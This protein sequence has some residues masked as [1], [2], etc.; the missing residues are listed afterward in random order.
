MFPVRY[1]TSGLAV[2]TTSRALSA[3]GVSIRSLKAPPDGA[4]VSM[5]MYLP[6]SRLPEVAIG[7]VAHSDDSGGFW[8]DFVLL[9]P[10]ARARIQ[11]LVDPAG[12]REGPSARRAFAR[13]SVDLRVR[14]R[15]AREFAIESASNLSRA[16]VFIRCEEPPELESEVEVQFE[17]PD[18][19]IVN[20]RGVVVHREANGDRPR[21]VG[22]QFVDAPD[23]FRERID[24]FMESLSGA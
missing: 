12:G 7:R 2:Q 4:R 1:V 24:R 18:G 5:A 21:G 23:R 17:L 13:H 15:T 22:V 10:A 3:S 14:L 11:H 16:G 6:S 9:D 19:E 20:S 8:V